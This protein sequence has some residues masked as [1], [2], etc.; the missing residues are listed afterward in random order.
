MAAVDDGGG[1]G[2]DGV[3]GSF[4]LSVAAAAQ[5][6]SRSDG[7]TDGRSAG[8]TGPDLGRRRRC[9]GN[10]PERVRRCVAA[11]GRGRGLLLCDCTVHLESRRFV[12]L[13]HFGTL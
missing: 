13:H 9:G 6:T 11:A 7:Q 1:G 3:N 2:D 8:G 12:V 4:H 10:R 5:T